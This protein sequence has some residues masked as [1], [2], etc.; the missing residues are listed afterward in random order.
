MGV[1]SKHHVEV[2]MAEGSEDKEFTILGF[3]IVK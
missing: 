3:G 2:R 1:S